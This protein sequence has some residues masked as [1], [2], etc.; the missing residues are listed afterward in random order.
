MR[1]EEIR[2]I[3]ELR[4]DE[5][6][7]KARVDTMGRRYKKKLVENTGANSD[8]YS[9]VRVNDRI[10]KYHRVVKCLALKQD[11]P[12]GIEV[13]H[14]DGNRTNNSPDNLRLVTTRENQ[15]NTHKHRAGKKVGVYFHK[16]GGKWVA[17]IQINGKHYY[18]GLYD[19]ELEA[20]EAY[21]K[22]FAL[23]QWYPTEYHRLITG[24]DLRAA[25]KAE[26]TMS[27]KKLK[28]TLDKRFGICYNQAS[29]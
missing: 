2:E 1:Y 18:L 21:L 29:V 7:R 22:A 4:G 17:Q 23:I 27:L 8:G 10:E 26:T 15:H 24:E 11:L 3:F 5:L 12:P 20:H 14:E 13:D 9:Q 25:A 16:A 28:K 6:W 19:T